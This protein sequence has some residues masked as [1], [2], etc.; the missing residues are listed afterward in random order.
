LLPLCII[1][2]VFA[3]PA[4]IWLL[5]VVLAHHRVVLAILVGAL[6]LL[7]VFG[8]AVNGIIVR[9]LVSV[10]PIV[11]ILLIFLLLLLS[12]LFWILFDRTESL[13]CGGCSPA[14]VRDRVLRVIRVLPN[15]LSQLSDDFSH[16]SPS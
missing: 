4:L 10:I 1:L 6:L 11:V 8:V 2:S 12:L 7:A 13:T 16:T 15:I 14:F 3:I 5:F 9:I